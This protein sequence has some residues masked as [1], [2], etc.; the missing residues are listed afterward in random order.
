M[1]KVIVDAG[2]HDL[3][4]LKKQTNGW[5]A[6]LETKL[7]DYPLDK[8]E[9]ITG[10]PA[11]D[12][13]KLALEY[14][15][16]KKSFIRANYGLNRH[17]NSGQMCRAVLIL[18][19]ITGAWREACGGACFGNLEEMWFRCKTDKLH[20]PDLG[21]RER[22]LN[23]VQLGQALTQNIDAKGEQLDPP[24]KS[25]FVYNSDPAN[26]A[27]NSNAVRKGLM[28]DDVFIAVHETFWTDTCNYADIVIPADTQLERMDML[29]T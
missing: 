19:A 27:P 12:I 14:A 20:R 15:S 23:M 5:E 11:T 4:F 17:Q 1:M 25:L 24:I 26:S 16:T 18:P 9:K 29:A 21:T 3:E 22:D 28:R 8:V 7:P 6:L 2:K 10:V 13:E